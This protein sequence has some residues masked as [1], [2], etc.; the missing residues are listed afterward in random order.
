MWIKPKVIILLL[1][2]ILFS[3]SSFASVNVFGNLDVIANDKRISFE[4]AEQKIQQLIE[5]ITD[6]LMI[7]S[8]I[9]HSSDHARLCYTYEQKDKY[10][11]Y[12]E[13]VF[14][15]MCRLVQINTAESIRQLVD[16]IHGDLGVSNN[17]IL[18][19][20]ITEIGRPSLLHLKTKLRELQE[21]GNTFNQESKKLVSKR[22]KLIEC[23]ID[24]I[25]KGKRIDAGV[26]PCHP[27]IKN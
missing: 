7:K 27:E 25:N 1:V 22:T 21:K 14:I 5:G 13:A 19:Q 15:G 4:N 2:G 24:Y 18:G 9:L 16:L 23:Y 17:E 10:E 11:R 3:P 8:I 6:P 20:R 12:D 26:G